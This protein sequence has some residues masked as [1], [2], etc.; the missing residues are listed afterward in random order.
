MEFFLPRPYGR[1]Q[2]SETTF[3]KSVVARQFS[4]P[5]EELGWPKDCH[6][7]AGKEVGWGTSLC[8]LQDWNTGVAV[9]GSVP[10]V[11]SMLGEI[12]R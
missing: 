2:E 11:A 5:G 9:L 4:N 10:R 6:L 12:P 1:C 8:R 3:T 7:A